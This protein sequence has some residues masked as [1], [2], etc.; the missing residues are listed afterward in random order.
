M[1]IVLL[2]LLVLVV[3]STA[4]SSSESSSSSSSS[5]SAASCKHAE[6]KKYSA[7]VR[8]YFLEAQL[9]DW[10]YA[11]SGFDV[12]KGVEFD[13]AANVFVQNANSA[14]ECRVG[15]TYKKA[16]YIQ[17]TDS[18][19]TKQVAQPS[20]LGVQ[21]PTLRAIVGDTIKVTLK[22]SASFDVTVHPHGVRYTKGNEGALAN[23]GTL[24]AEKHDDMVAPGH[25][26]T[27]TWLADAESGP[28]PNDLSSQVW[29]YHS[30][31]DEVADTN[32]GLYG[33]LI[34]ADPNCA[35]FETA[36]PL[37]V[38]REFVIVMTVMDENAALLLDDSIAEFCP[39]F[40]GDAEELKGD[41]DFVESNL[42]HSVNGYVFGNLPG[43]NMVEG[44]TVRWNLI[45]FGT[46]VDL[47]EPH[48]HGN[49][50]LA[51]GHRRDT[52]ELLPLTMIGVD[53]HATRRGAFLFHCHVND[54]ITAGMVALYSVINRA[55]FAQHR[56]TSTTAVDD[57]AVLAKLVASLRNKNI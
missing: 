21:G 53:M 57:E 50:V 22:N 12:A 20:W 13:D 37:D 43:L 14:S 4:S 35:D 11:P 18:T 49:T 52:V 23:D 45:G 7:R 24:E 47:H 5:S 26:F 32:T 6:G 27:Y 28:G 31:V 34:I 39:A 41:D 19:F 2:G 10:D 3:S 8:E 38:D 54:H 40:A 42:M 15:S 48:W 46:E 29:A 33:A 9:V 25:T 30:H 17:F 1:L 51:A 44:E 36:K 55:V 16:R 56:S